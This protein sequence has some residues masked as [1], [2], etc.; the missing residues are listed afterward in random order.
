MRR[1]WVDR[2]KLPGTA[3]SDVTLKL[4]ALLC[5]FFVILALLLMYQSPTAGYELSIYS[6]TP[7]GAWVFLFLSVL[8][9]L[10]IVVHQLA[11]G[12]YQ[13]TRTYLVGFAVVML[14]A[15]AFLCLPVIR[16]YF[17]W[18]GDQMA[19]IGFVKDIATSGHLPGYNPYPV[20]HTMLFEI[21]AVLDW[22]IDKVVNLNTPLIFIV[23]ILVT[24]LLTTVV[25]PHRGQQLTATL[26][27]AATLAAMSRFNLV[28]NTW[29]ILLLPL[30]F[31]CY[32]RRDEPPF[33]FLLVMLI[34]VY[35]FLHP[36]SALMVIVSLMAIELLKPIY[37]GVLRRSGVEVPHWIGAGPVI[38]PLAMELLV[39]LPWVFTRSAFRSNVDALWFQLVNF[40]GS[41]QGTR[42]V[43]SL[44]KVDLNAWGIVMIIVKM[45]GEIFL[46]GVLASLGILLVYWQLRSLNRDSGGSESLSRHGGRQMR[47]RDERAGRQDW[48][49]EADESQYGDGE[50][51]GDDNRFRLVFIGVLFVIFTLAYFA[52]YAGAPGAESLSA[53]RIVVYVEVAAV[54]LVGFALWQLAGRA[55]HK[56][57]AWGAVSA[58]IIVACV[59]NVAGHH[60]APYQLRPGDEV[61]DSDIQGMEWLLQEKDPTAYTFFIMSSP[62]RFSQA[63]L[64]ATVTSTR[65]DV[66]D[67]SW[68]QFRDHFGYLESHDVLDPHKHTTVGEQF[69]VDMYANINKYD[70]VAYQTVWKSLDRF[71]DADFAVFEQDPTVNRI[72]SDGA[73]DAYYITGHMQEDSGA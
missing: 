72:Y 38:W 35:P 39:F 65:T 69:A 26:F 64:G 51:G 6:A 21:S 29:S 67:T 15:T 17:T 23:F 56:V 9:G 18:R 55:R 70:K 8:G 62:D 34:L 1:P 28:P 44:A 43:E 4:L 61:S 7:P 31:Y 3:K 57:F 63:I 12:R 33:K 40:S 24:F 58:V 36:L 19:H 30:F 32:F 41:S 45:Y 27:A 52:F 10:F 46:V 49:R 16:N 25:L 20:T 14:A 53:T 59:L 50:P 37:S 47:S 13:E 22:P 11:T 66:M 48:T 2:R 5:V 60:N 54:P 73:S 68:L 71:N 42:A